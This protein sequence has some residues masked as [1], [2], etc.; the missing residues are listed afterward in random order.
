MQRR[1]AKDQPNGF[2]NRIERVAIVGAGGQ[3]GS[4]ITEHLLL[5][6][7]HTLTAITRLNSTSTFPDGVKVVRANYS[8]PNDEGLLEALRGQQ[9]LIITM[10]V[11]APRD[12]VSN[13]IRAAV[14]AGVSYVMPNW[15]GV[16][17][18]N[19]PLCDDCFPG[20]MS[21][22]IHA[23][24]ESPDGATSSI[25]LACSFWYEFSLG[26]GTDR[27]GFDF[28][29]RA[30]VVF[31]DGNV[32]I[33]TS[34]WPQCTRAVAALLS[35]KEFPEDETDESPSLSQFRNRTVYIKS[36]RLSQLEMF[37]SV[38]RVTG[39]TEADWTISH[40]S[41][42]QRYKEGRA[43][44]EQ[45]NFAEFTKMLYSRMFY[46]QGSVEYPRD[47]DNLL[48]GLPVEDLDE[49]TAVAIRMGENGE[50]TGHY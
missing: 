20:H 42:E 50:V 44:L 15:F 37:E 19:K 11:T 13:L 41:S 30:F 14:K 26:G 21:D 40:E 29:K 9:V 38:K 28:Q 8:D 31:D 45:G 48:L 25:L 36:F 18:G 34:T 47:V 3:I 12:T 5:T 33:N 24:I 1:Y 39:T 2:T 46:T 10:S 16:D 32:A 6:G 17:P 27:Y 7:K 23:T 49:A 43:A 4:V 35:L 22:N